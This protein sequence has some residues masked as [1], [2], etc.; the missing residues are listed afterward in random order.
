MSSK[1]HLRRRACANKRTYDTLAEAMGAARSLRRG[2]VHAYGC[3]F[4]GKFHVGHQ[5]GTGFFT[6]QTTRR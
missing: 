4:C 1:R 3:R 6:T 5:R 2:G